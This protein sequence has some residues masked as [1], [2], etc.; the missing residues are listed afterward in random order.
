MKKRILIP[1]LLCAALLTG[2]SGNSQSEAEL[3]PM[4]SLIQE[5]QPQAAPSYTGLIYYV[6]DHGTPDPAQMKRL[7]ADLEAEGHTWQADVLAKVPAA[8]DTILVLNAPAEDITEQDLKALDTFF[9]AGGHML[10]LM[11]ANDT[12][13][14]YKYLERALEEYCIRMDYDLVTDAAE[15]HSIKGTNA[16]LINSIPAPEGMSP[17]EAAYTAPLMMNDVRSF[18]FFYTEGYGSIHMDALLETDVTAV[19]TPFGGVEEDPETFEGKALMTMLYAYDDKR[20]NAS[21]VAVGAA[22]FLSDAKYDDTFSEKP[23]TWVTAAITWM[24]W[25]NNR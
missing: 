22:D 13:M 25:L 15:G 14:R 2:C 12:Q 1:L 23:R 7:Q 4:D 18:S 20:N 9:D 24:V 3:P 10:L 8:S 21:V 11:P 16:V 19:G 6:T 17:G 5:E